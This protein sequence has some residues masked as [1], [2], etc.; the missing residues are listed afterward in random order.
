MHIYKNTLPHKYTHSNFL[1][2]YLYYISDESLYKT[3]IFSLVSECIRK[4]D[5]LD[6]LSIDIL[7]SSIVLVYRNKIIISDKKNKD[8]EINILV[9]KYLLIDDDILV[10]SPK[11][12][13]YKISKNLSK[14]FTCVCLSEDITD[15]CVSD[16]FLYLVSKN[17]IFKK[18][19]LSYKISLS[20]PMLVINTG[21]TDIVIGVEIRK[22]FYIS[23]DKYIEVYD[24]NED[25][26]LLKYRYNTSEGFH[27]FRCNKIY[28]VDKDVL[29]LEE[30]PMIIY[31][32]RVRE[33][34]QNNEEDILIS[35]E[36]IIIN[37]KEVLINDKKIIRHSTSILKDLNTSI[38]IRS[39]DTE[40]SIINKYDTE[41]L[42]RYR[43]LYYELSTLN[44]SLVLKKDKL[45]ILYN[46][47]D[48]KIKDHIKKKEGIKRRMRDLNKKYEEVLGKITIEGGDI[49]KY[50]GVVE[51][52][53]KKKTKKTDEKYLRILKMQKE[54][55]K[56]KVM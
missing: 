10:L 30:Y 15:F 33:I 16:K 22:Y 35:N 8:K 48:K 3:N 23:Y 18:Y 42:D 13:L 40:K 28:L 27:I 46:E 24:I 37:H 12:V 55:L 53:M 39:T 4:V 21:N 9:K 43:I 32:G 7:G 1:S 56:K 6:I 54:L 50:I 38:V 34:Y 49:K 11:N 17:K 26:L 45:D 14:D 47:V 31:Q 19:L 51:E 2:P 52:E 44:D 5:T 29:I 36:Y 20:S 41:I 25:I